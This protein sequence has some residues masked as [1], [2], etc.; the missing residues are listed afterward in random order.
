MMNSN[1]MPKESPVQ[2]SFKQMFDTGKMEGI[3]SDQL[4][5]LRAMVGLL[6]SIDGKT[7]TQG[8]PAAPTPKA[9]VPP[10]D[11]SIPNSSINLSRKSLQT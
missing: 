8:Q 3:L 10:T 11:R 9:A 5:E 2:E 1:S 4:T 6:R 7:G